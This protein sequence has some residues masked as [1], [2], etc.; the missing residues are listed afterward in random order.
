VFPFK[1]FHFDVS[2]LTNILHRST[3]PN[4]LTDRPTP[5]TPPSLLTL[6]TSTLFALS[7]SVDGDEAVR[8]V[9]K[10][11]LGKRVQ[12]LIALLCHLVRSLCTLVTRR[13]LLNLLTILTKYLLSDVLEPVRRVH[14]TTVRYCEERTG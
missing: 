1:R 5:P 14:E 12:Q 8:F 7:Q 2:N 13:T 11:L 9:E 3:D 4:I 6:L 10:L